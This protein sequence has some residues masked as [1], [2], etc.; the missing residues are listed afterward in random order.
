[1][2]EHDTVPRPPSPWKGSEHHV[3]HRWQMDC[4]TALPGAAALLRELAAELRS[5]HGAGWWLVEPMLNGH[6]VAAR[7]SRRQRARRAPGPHGVPPGLHGVPPGAGPAVPGW[8]L[9]V[10]QEPA[11]AGEEPLDSAAAPRTAVLLWTGRSLEQV[12]G[13]EVPVDVLAEIARQAASQ[14]VTA[15]RWAVGA[16]RVGPGFDLVADGS[17]LRVHAVVD[18]ALVRTREVL[19]FQHAADGA[20]D[21]LQAATAYEGLA[22]EAEAMAAVGGR[23]IGADDGFLHIGYD[24]PSR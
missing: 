19:S 12:G 11:V 18:G 16:A 14:D 17:A 23:L 9:R 20:A 4:A 21:L 10:V 1:M 13:P 15:G 7:A 6:L 2:T 24:G 22:E 8:R 3:R 5:A